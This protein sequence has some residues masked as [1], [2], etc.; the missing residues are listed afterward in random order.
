M[1]GRDVRSRDAACHVHKGQCSRHGISIANALGIEAASFARGTGKSFGDV[2]EVTELV[3]VPSLCLG[4][5][6]G[7]RRAKI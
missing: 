6:T 3:E 5:E 7:M 4:S 2:N 1:K